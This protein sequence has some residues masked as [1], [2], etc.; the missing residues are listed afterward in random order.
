MEPENGEP[1]ITRP[2]SISFGTPSTGVWK[3]YVDAKNK[4]EAAGIID[5]AVELFKYAKEK[6]KDARS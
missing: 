1:A 6:D 5:N 2:D 4:E 3:A